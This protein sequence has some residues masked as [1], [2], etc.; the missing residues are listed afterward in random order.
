MAAGMLLALGDRTFSNPAMRAELRGLL[1]E[2][3]HLCVRLAF[4]IDAK[5]G[6]GMLAAV[7]EVTAGWDAEEAAQPAAGPGQSTAPLHA[8]DAPDAAAIAACATTLILA[9]ALATGRQQRRRE[10]PTFGAARSHVRRHGGWEPCV[11]RRVHL[12]AAAASGM[13]TRAARSGPFGKA[14]L[15]RVC[16][17]LPIMLLYRNNI[18]PLSNAA[19]TLGPAQ[20]A[21]NRP[22]PRS[23]RADRRAG[24]RR[25]GR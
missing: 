11:V 4:R 14:G 22:P 12:R 3:L 17:G 24:G 15:R 19:A 23:A 6:N 13:R 16:F 21:P 1:R 10:T 7:A 18:R 8:T 20:S 9:A 5:T 25:I 2:M